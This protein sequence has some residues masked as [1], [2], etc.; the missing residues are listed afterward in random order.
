M[1]K[2]AWNTKKLYPFL[3]KGSCFVKVN[4]LLPESDL[5]NVNLYKLFQGGQG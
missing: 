3:V 2:L 1:F 4:K 5:L